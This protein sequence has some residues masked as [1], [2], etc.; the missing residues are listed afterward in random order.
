MKNLNYDHQLLETP[1]Q[2]G[3]GLITAADN[4]LLSSI[5]GLSTLLPASFT[6]ALP[7]HWKGKSPDML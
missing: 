5:I 3:A 2:T 7:K 6:K 4:S 1:E